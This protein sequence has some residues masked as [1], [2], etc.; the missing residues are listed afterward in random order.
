M[1]WIRIPVP[2]ADEK[3]RRDLC[4]AL[5]S[6]GLE[7]RIIRIRK[8]KNASPSR[9]VEYRDTNSFAIKTEE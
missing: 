2:I 9:Y 1:D 6:N 4:S 8:S 5:S 7:V 3:D